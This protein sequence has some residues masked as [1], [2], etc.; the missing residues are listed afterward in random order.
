MWFDNTTQLQ[1]EYIDL[2]LTV[3]ER[4]EEKRWCETTSYLLFAHLVAQHP[5]IVVAAARPHCI[6]LH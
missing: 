1:E 6:A 2:K 3:W 4:R 5:H